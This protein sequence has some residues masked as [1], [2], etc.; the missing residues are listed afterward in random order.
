MTTAELVDGH[1][2]R[3]AARHDAFAKAHRG[4][5]KGHL[6][7]AGHHMATNPTLAQIHRDVSQ[8]HSNLHKAHQACQ[9]DFDNLREALAEASDADVLDSHA[10]E[11]RNMQ[12]AFGPVDLLKAARLLPAD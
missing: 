5:A 3:M 9:E 1:L 11:T 7:A 4:V 8:H 12:H 10:N 6:D 2:K